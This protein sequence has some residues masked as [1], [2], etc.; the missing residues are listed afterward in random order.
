MR[1]KGAERIGESAE[2]CPTPT[3]ASQAPE[4]KEFQEYWVDLPTRQSEEVH[5]TVWKA[6]VSK[7]QSKH[8]VVQR[9]KELHNIKCNN[10]CF[11]TLGPASSDQM[12]Q[13]HTSIFS[14][15][16]GHTSQLVGMENAVLDSIKLKLPH[17][18]LLNELAKCVEQNNRPQVSRSLM[19]D[20]VF[21]FS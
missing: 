12:S 1:I 15:P 3:S 9:G 4:R 18:H 6:K 19:V 13:K 16:L 7:N 5:N 21:S 2:P 20:S 17:N 14:R 11:K 8:T 10:T